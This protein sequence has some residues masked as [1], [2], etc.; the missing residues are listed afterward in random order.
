MPTISRRRFLAQTGALFVGLSGDALLR[1]DALFAQATPAADPL[2][3][4][5][6]ELVADLERTF[7]YASALYTASDGI[8][9]A[10]DR[11]GKQVTFSP[12]RGHGVSLRV[13]DGVSFHEAATDDVS[14][15]ALRAAVQ[16]LKRDVAP[17]KERFHIEP[18]PALE[19]SWKTELEI[20]PESL[21]LAERA[22]I[23]DQ[24]FASVDWS[25]SRV[26]SVRVSTDESRVR[27]I[28]VDRTRRL[29]SEI[30]QVSHGSF[31]FGLANGR[32]GAAFMR[33]IRQGGYE[34]AR[35]D[36][37]AIEQLRVEL[38]EMFGAERVPGGEYD[39]IFSPPV[40]GLLAHESFGHG[41]EMDQFVKDRAKAR[42]FLGKKVAAEIV[43][44]SDDP[45]V[46]GMRGSYPFDDEGMLSAPTRIID[47]GIFVSP[48]TD[49]MSSTYLGRPRTPNGRTQAWDRK[50]YARMSNTFIERGD[51]DPNAMIAGMEDGL[52]L[53]GFRNGI[54]DPQGWGIQFT[55][56]VAREIKKG[57]F[58]GKV[59]TP[60]TVSGYVPEIL[61]NVTQ[62]GSDFA[63]EP[64]SCGKGFKEFVPVGSGGPHVRTRARVS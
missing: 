37:E 52:Y 42:E 57:K 9:M 20:D 34:N 18:L 1:P 35:F 21:T 45:T 56:R 50:V 10:R 25:D 33:R 48:I 24:E 53:D 12:F 63:I 51:T 58:T 36:E 41:V 19:R 30:V 28:F 32:P 4:L 60:I 7:S 55:T 5:L 46:N 22:A 8:Q 29:A 64:G 38:V 6:G 39:C 26:R 40:T 59:Y 23:L 44:L 14:A 13:W 27:R 3:L 31:M 43:S 61:G 49:L 47:R 15:D 2:V 62:V 16:R 54:E 17:Q 11:N